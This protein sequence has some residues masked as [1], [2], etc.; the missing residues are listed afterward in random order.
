MDT[1]LLPAAV[2]PDPPIPFIDEEIGSAAHEK[3]MPSVRAVALDPGHGL[4]L[5][6]LV[7]ADASVSAVI[8]ELLRS[9]SNGV[10]F[11]PTLFASQSANIPTQLTIQP[12]IRYS[13]FRSALATPGGSIRVKNWCLLISTANIAESRRHAPIIPPQ[14]LPPSSPATP[15]EAASAQPTNQ[16]PPAPPPHY[17]IG[18]ASA[19]LPNPHALLGHLRAI[20]VVAADAWAETMR[21]LA[22]DAQLVMPIPATGVTCW[23][24]DADL[25]K[26]VDLIRHGIQSRRFAIPGQTVISQQR[27]A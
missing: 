24:I 25:V 23:R 5:L 18:A 3:H 7:G 16:P 17:V 9:K 8:M 4:V 19:M 21:D 22:L 27:A 12:G 15:G 11:M 1:L 6:N 2:E 14:L 13:I 26:W 10:G 20:G